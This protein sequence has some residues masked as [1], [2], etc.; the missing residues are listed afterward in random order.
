MRRMVYVRRL[1]ASTTVTADGYSFDLR[2]VQD[3]GEQPVIEE[4]FINGSTHNA[5]DFIDPK[6]I[7]YWA[8]SL[9]EEAASLREDYAYS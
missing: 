2:W 6:M 4:V 1:N 9:A 8:D 3:P 5:I 7:S